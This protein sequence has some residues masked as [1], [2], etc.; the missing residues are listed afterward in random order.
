MEGILNN[1]VARRIFRDWEM[2]AVFFML[3]LFGDGW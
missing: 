3:Y 1:A 2:Y